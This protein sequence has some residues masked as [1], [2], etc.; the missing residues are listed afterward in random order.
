MHEAHFDRHQFAG[1]RTR[2]VSATKTR[3]GWDST[4]ISF[5]DLGSMSVK[6]RNVQWERRLPTPQWAVN[7]EQLRAVVLRFAEDRLYNFSRN[8]DHTGTDQ[9]RM[10]RIAAESKRVLPGIKQQLEEMLVTA[11]EL[12]SEGVKSS[13]ARVHARSYA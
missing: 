8:I 4:G 10:D 13:V 7:D 2:A 1:R 11:A 9:E 3:E 12:E 6:H 5:G